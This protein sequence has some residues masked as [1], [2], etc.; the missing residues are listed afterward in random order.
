MNTRVASAGG[1]FA[2]FQMSNYQSGLLKSY[3]WFAVI[4]LTT[5][6]VCAA[7]YGISMLT[8]VVNS[9]WVAPVIL[10]KSDPHVAQLAAQVFQA[11]QNYDQM[12][13]ELDSAEQAHN[14]LQTQKDWLTGI[15][16]RYEHSL[17][18]EKNANAQF[19][20]QLQTLVAERKAINARS[21]QLV[22]ANRQV[23]D[24]I[25]Q[26]LKAGLVTAVTATQARAGLVSAEQALADSK[27]AVA[28]IDNQISQLTR[29][30]QSLGGGN[31]S[32]EAMQSLAQVSILKQELNETNLKLVQLNADVKVK[33]KEAT[34][35]L[36]MLNGLKTSPYYMAAYGDK[37]VRRFAFVPYD[38][39]DAAHIGAPVYS[40]KAEI[41]LC[42]KVGRVKAIT[43]D[44]EHA[45]H[46]LFST[47]LRG[48][49]V[50]LDLDDAKAAKDQVLFV[51]HSPF[52]IL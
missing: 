6:L 35:L 46:P 34:E 12:K 41:V 24:G 32:P 36:S 13:G 45:Q 47:Q 17:G 29:G 7:G 31:S 16:A 8:F 28:T 26:S 5:I 23:S 42:S 27:V 52:Y 25:D 2:R 22:A 10:S 44:E 50:E 38:N 9:S 3:R 15:I 20:G 4:I 19:N 49:L 21:A 33:G 18:D 51:G 48:V 11:K 40:C 30:V 39:E 43:K 14:L 1:F 37:D